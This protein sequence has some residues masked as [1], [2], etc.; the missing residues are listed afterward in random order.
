[1]LKD[2][3]GGGGVGRG[4]NA[5]HANN[6]QIVHFVGGVAV[7]LP[8]NQDSTFKDLNHDLENLTDSEEHQSSS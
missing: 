2:G 4:H 6:V 8:T 7:G 3:G 1:M 5:G